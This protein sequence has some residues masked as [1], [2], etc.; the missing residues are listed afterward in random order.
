V[1]LGFT[2]WIGSRAAVVEYKFFN[3]GH[4]ISKLKNCLFA[5]LLVADFLD[6]HLKMK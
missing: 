2:F 6:K 3:E 5:F 1:I 4:G